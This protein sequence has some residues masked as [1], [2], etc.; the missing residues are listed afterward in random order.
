MEIAPRYNPKEVE[1]KI[2]KKWLEDS[3]F[4]AKPNKSKK[5]FSIAIPPPNITGILH[6][7]HALNDTLQDVLIRFKR[8]QG[9]EALWMPGTDHAGIATQNVVERDLAKQNLKKEDIGREEFIKKLW[10]WTDKYGSTIINQLKRLG[11][12]CDWERLRFTMDEPYSEAVKEVFVR[13]YEKGLI[14]RGKRI[15]NWCPRCKTALSDE[16]ASHKEINGW[17]YYIKYPVLKEHQSTGH[18]SPEKQYVIVATTRP[19]TMLGDTA[20]AIN[21]KDERFSWLK[22][23]KVILPI[24]ERELKVIEDEVVDVEFG[25]GVVKVTPSHDP[26]DFNL[27]KKHNLE[28]INIMN[29]DATLNDYAGEFAGMDRFEAREAILEVLEEKKL[30]EKKETYKVSAGHCYRCHTIIEPRISPQWFVKMK[31]LAEPAIKAVEEDKIKFYPQR[32]KKVYLNWMNNIQDWCIS[33]QIWWGHRLPVYYCSNC[34]AGKLQIPN[35]KSQTNSN[36]QNSNDTLGIIVSKVKPEKCPDCGLA[37]LV[38]DE[39]VLDTWFSSWLWPFAT[40]YWPFTEPSAVSFQSSDKI[41][42]LKAD[43]RK[44]KAEL[45]YFYPTSVLVTASEILFFWVA[46]MIMAGFEFKKEIPFRDVIIHGTVRDARGIKMSKS[47]GNIIDPLEVIEK[48]GADSLRF[49][50]MLLAAGGSDVYLSDE[51]FLVGRN[52]SNKIWNATRFIFLKIS[53]SGIKIEDLSLKE[54]DEIDT[55]LINE[56]NSVIENA[57]RHLENYRINE[58]TKCIYEFF[59]HTFCDWYVEIIKDNFSLAKGKV[60]IYAL[61][62]SIKLLHPIM[63]F[64]T[65]EVFHLIEQSLSLGLEDNLLRSK[66]PLPIKIQAGSG[67][68]KKIN[69]LFETIG[70]IRNIKADLG[71]GQKKVKLQ[72]KTSTENE[73]YLK[74]Y[75]GW[76]KRLAYLEAFVFCKSLKRVIY[77]NELW[78][79]NLDIE[80]IDIKDFV[81]TLDK[82]IKNLDGVCSKISGRLNNENFLKNAPQET[83]EA[84]KNKFREINLQ[85]NRLKELKNAFR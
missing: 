35:S 77:K 54:I 3:L 49:S 60:A 76:I 2:L 18:Q 67:S 53:E 62:N 19:E 75:E 21:P 32:W 1:E 68:I 71:I 36:D 26:V 34:Q 44:L 14:Y 48:F 42:E 40:F 17:L 72:I 15:I 57:T 73:K 23:A 52:F 12:S 63:P 81:S 65:E 78:E 4:S 24:V 61:I 38:Q 55:W 46:R 56:L 33:R 45:D 31:P 66:W 27:G 85:L 50:L 8:M 64:I 16:E 82:K 79:L 69:T 7:G 43:S 84:E 9:Y 30:I 13:L 25:T 37:N 51:K 59:W 22:N 6:M 5:P 11:Y 70:E 58:A 47:L 41:K 39:D 10:Q 80:E 20:V 28:F 29:E 74:A 83:V